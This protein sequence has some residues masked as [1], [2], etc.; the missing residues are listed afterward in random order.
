VCWKIQVFVVFDD[1]PHLFCTKSKSIGR[2]NSSSITSKP[3]RCDRLEEP[4]SQIVDLS[5]TEKNYRKKH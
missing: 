4:L 5:F 2:D 1:L 3:A